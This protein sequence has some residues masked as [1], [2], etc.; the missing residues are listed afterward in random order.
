M[1]ILRITELYTF[2][3]MNRF[4]SIIIC[5]LVLS[6]SL[7][8]S[9]SADDNLY[10][11][12]KDDIS[13]RIWDL[14]Y[15]PKDVKEAAIIELD[16]LIEADKKSEY[17]DMRKAL[18]YDTKMRSFEYSEFDKIYEYSQL[19]RKH[20]IKLTDKSM[21]YNTWFYAVENDFF[22]GDIIRAS[23]QGKAMFLSATADGNT[24]GRAVS[25]YTLALYFTGEELYAEAYPYYTQALPLFKDMKRWGY[26]IVCAINSIYTMG[27][28]K[29]DDGILPLFNTLDSLADESL[30]GDRKAPLN[31]NDI[32]NIK[33]SCASEVFREP[34][35]SLNLKKYLIQLRDIYERYGSD[36]RHEVPLFDV[37]RSYAKLVGNIDN[38]LSY[39]KKVF[40]YVEKAHDYLNMRVESRKL[41]DC[42]ER[43]GNTAEALYYIK[44]YTALNDSLNEITKKS[45]ISAMAAEYGLNRLSEKNE[46]LEEQVIWNRKVR[47]WLLLSVLILVII[48]MVVIIRNYKSR[49]KTLQQ[50]NEMKTDFIRGITHEINTPLNAVLGFSEV[51]ANMSKDPEQEMLAGLVKTN[52]MRL[53]KL[54]DDTLYLSD[55]DSGTIVNLTPRKVK[56]KNVLDRVRSRVVENMQ[57]EEIS[58]TGDDDIEMTLHEQ[59]LETLMYNL[60]HNGVEHGK[61][62]VKVYYYKDKSGVLSISVKDSGN[63]IAAE[64][65]EKIF[66]RFFKGNTYTNG[67][68]VGLAVARIAVER[69]GGTVEYND[70][71]QVGTEFVV[72]LK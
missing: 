1:V 2:F 69:L 39:S 42:Y 9:A 10:G 30:K 71:Q 26:Y 37:E 60:I 28:L 66:E 48:I 45:I 36:I 51:I 25:A 64:L 65:R 40:E 34:K 29:I 59:S 31:I 35:D 15:E 53:T 23:E 63:G 33:G 54:V 21:Y 22:G 14:F 43:M 5:A 13:K 3:L 52:S 56:I 50:V 7:T 57:C 41:S 46:E 18:V 58:V 11:V 16:S 4:L 8:L 72:T 6:I 61:L 68:G 44:R 27:N 12:D 49:N 70:K 38:E 32:V 24:L 55:Y 20:S 17:Y 19:S 47:T 67:L 62:P